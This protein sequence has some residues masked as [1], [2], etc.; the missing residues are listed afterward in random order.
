MFS[1]SNSEYQ[2]VCVETWKYWCDKNDVDFIVDSELGYGYLKKY[3]KIGVMNN[4]I[5]VKWEANNIFNEFNTDDFCG[6]L[7]TINFKSIYDEVKFYKNFDISKY[8]N[9][10]AIFFGKKHIDLFESCLTKQI[11]INCILQENEINVKELSQNWNMG[12]LMT[13]HFLS[14]NWQL[15]EDNTPFFIKYGDIWNLKEIETPMLQQLWNTIGGM[16]K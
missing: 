7:D 5:M 12:G 3:D 11:P 15:K 2:E 13:R 10:D 9:P 8:I 1:D 16:Y 14:H 6:V 4:H